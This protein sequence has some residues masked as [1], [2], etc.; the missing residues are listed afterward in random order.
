[1]TILIA[2]EAEHQV[3][4]P[5]VVAPTLSIMQSQI[6]LPPKLE[7]SGNLAQNWKRWRQLWDSYG[8][9]SEI[10]Q[11][12]KE[13]Q[14]ATFITCIGMEDLEVYNGLPFKQEQD[15][16]DPKE[17]LRLMEEYFVGKTNIIYERY[18]FNNKSQELAETFDAY[19]SK[20]RKLAG[21]CNYEGICDELIRDRIVCGIR[22]NTI[23]KKLLQESEL[24]LDKCVNICRA[25]EKTAAQLKTMSGHEDV[26][27]VKQKQPNTTATTKP[28]HNIRKQQQSRPPRHQQ[29]SKSSVCKYCGKTHP[30]DKYK[31]QMAKHA[32]NATRKIILLQ[33]ANKPKEKV[34]S[35]L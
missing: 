18:I 22:D 2:H 32:Q 3:Q 31:C 19:V 8:I 26:H 25:A 13:Y 15:K 29:G 6:P 4:G 1:M 9:V 24:T 34:E 30:F 27:F 10:N 21:T 33:F 16:N 12:P 11:R 7:L 5:A 14:V 28:Q 17:I 23:R 20:L 35:T